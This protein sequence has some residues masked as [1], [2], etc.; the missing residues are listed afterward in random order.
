MYER[1]RSSKLAPFIAGILLATMAMFAAVALAQSLGKVGPVTSSDGTTPTFRATRSSSA[2]VQQSAGKY[3]EAVLRGN[4]Y[5]ASAGATGQGVNATI[6]TTA[7]FAL[8]NPAGSGK[9][10]RIYQVGLGYVSGTLGAATI[11]HAVNTSS[12]EAMPTAGTAVTPINALITGPN[13]SVAKC[14]FGSTLPATPTAIGALTS[15]FAELATTANAMQPQVFDIDGS[16]MVDQGGIWSLAAAGTAGT[17][18][19]LTYSV[20]WE[21]VALGAE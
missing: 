16:I 6:G 21:E 3:S 2:V 20:F 18:P 8:G 7:M 11:F 9:R 15:T 1:F 5:W 13:N 12:T 14:T 17:T 4:C 19:V 10:L